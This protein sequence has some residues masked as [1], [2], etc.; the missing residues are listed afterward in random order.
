MRTHQNS[1]SSSRLSALFY[2]GLL[3]LFLTAF[4]SRANA[5][6]CDSCPP[7]DTQTNT[8]AAGTQV[9]VNINPYFSQEQR[10]AVMQSFNNWQ[11]SSRNNTGIT[12]TFTFNS[13]P[14]SGANTYQVNLQTPNPPLGGGAARGETFQFPTSNNAHLDRAVTNIDPQ[15]TD[16][17]ALANLMAHEIGHTMG[18]Q[19]CY[20]CCPNVTVMASPATSYNDTTTGRAD[21]GF[22][23]AATANQVTGSPM[24]DLGGGSGGGGGGYYDYPCTP[25]YWVYYESWDG[26]QTWEL[27]DMWYAG[28][29]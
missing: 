5:Q 27:V 17:T 16:L 13:T 12:F 8:W 2:M 6:T 26:G 24:G 20:T 18:L 7:P 23:D 22:C 21:P 15:V 3:A 19:D 10:D 9:T 28:C 11:N 25:Y 29:W 14:I 1:P 4:T